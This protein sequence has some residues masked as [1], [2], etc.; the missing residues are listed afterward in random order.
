LGLNKILELMGSTN[1]GTNVSPQS[2]FAT[3]LLAVVLF[4]ITTAIV[5]VFALIFLIRIVA[6]W[7]LTVL[8]PLAY[9]FAAFPQTNGYANKWWGEFWKYAT[10]GP[11]LAF[12]LWLTLTITA[13]GNTY[14]LILAEQ[15]ETSS[16]GSL[17]TPIFSGDEGG[18]ALSIALSSVSTST[19]ILS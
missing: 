4:A 8:S 3:L 7:I 17:D 10:I 2:V 5:L 15:N 14:T 19:G 1:V 11:V 18:D 6:L 9:V 16:V 12:F 13:A